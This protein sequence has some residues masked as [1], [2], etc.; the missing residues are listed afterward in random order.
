MEEIN[1]TVHSPGVFEIRRA[2]QCSRKSAP[3]VVRAISRTNKRFAKSPFSV[4]Q[5]DK[6]SLKYIDPYRKIYKDA[7]VTYT[8]KKIRSKRKCELFKKIMSER[9]NRYFEILKRCVIYDT[10]WMREKLREEKEGVINMTKIETKSI[11]D[12]FLLRS[13]ANEKIN[14]QRN[15]LLKLKQFWNDYIEQL[16]LRINS[17]KELILNHLE[18]NA[19]KLNTVEKKEN[20]HIE[21]MDFEGNNSLGKYKNSSLKELEQMKLIATGYEMTVNKFSKMI[22]SLTQRIELILGAEKRL[23]NVAKAMIVNSEKT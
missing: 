20:L 19:E 2:G 5:M 12:I 18:I 23:N 17:E 16:K 11:V 10:D 21:N 1:Y 7:I 6:I 22:K 9:E 15:L 14:Q 13:V 8:E 4:E 3:P